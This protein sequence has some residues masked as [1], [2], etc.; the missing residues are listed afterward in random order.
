MDGG[1]RTH[2]FPSLTVR[3]Q[4]AARPPKRTTAASHRATACD[5]QTLL[6]LPGSSGLTACALVLGRLPLVP[7]RLRRGGGHGRT[8]TCITQDDHSRGPPWTT[9]PVARRAHAAGLHTVGEVRSISN[10]APVSCS[11]VARP[12]AA[13]A[14]SS[15]GLLSSGTWSSCSVVVRRFR[16]GRVRLLGCG[17][18]LSVS[19]SL[20]FEGGSWAFSLPVPVLPPLPLVSAV[21]LL[22]RCWRPPNSNVS[23][24]RLPPFQAPAALFF[25]P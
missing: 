13:R 2:D 18:C 3:Y 19:G 21:R 25:C 16:A 5:V 15:V 4:A 20:V 12:Q 7:F 22:A 17:L 9:R 6:S 1:I 14:H 24:R 11:V 23:S 10:A 8:C